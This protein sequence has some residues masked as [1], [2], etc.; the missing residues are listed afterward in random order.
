MHY[1]IFKTNDFLSAILTDGCF[2]TYLLWF[3]HVRL[4]NLILMLSIAYV[5]WISSLKTK[6][7]QNFQRYKK[8]RATAAYCF[9]CGSLYIENMYTG[10]S[11]SK[12][13]MHK[14]VFF[15]FPFFPF[16]YITV[17]KFKHGCLF[18]CDD[19]KMWHLLFLYIIRRVV[20]DVV[21]Q[22]LMIY[23]ARTDN[24]IKI[25]H[26]IVTWRVSRRCKTCSLQLY[27][28]V[29]STCG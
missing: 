2:V 25:Q 19:V 5:L 9:C 8:F 15:Y 12:C 23:P 6:L 11:T 14:F 24:S 17:N 4:L 20:S 29:A 7:S 13:F 22:V 28:E 21:R 18:S 16:L 10:C 26:S 27:K 3:Y 1:R